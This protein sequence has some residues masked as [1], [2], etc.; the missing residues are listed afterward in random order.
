MEGAV[1]HEAPWRRIYL[2]PFEPGTAQEVIS[3]ARISTN[4]APNEAMVCHLAA[5]SLL[6]ADPISQLLEFRLA[7]RLTRAA[8]PGV[9]SAMGLF[10]VGLGHLPGTPMS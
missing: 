9:C 1:V 3:Q 4:S 10:T 2:R 6:C 8:Q 5:R 7:G